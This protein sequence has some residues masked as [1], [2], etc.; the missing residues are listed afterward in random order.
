MKAHKDSSFKDLKKEFRDL[1]K[2]HIK[3]ME[4]LE[5]YQQKEEK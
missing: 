5:K 1:T 4:Y 3:A 2:K